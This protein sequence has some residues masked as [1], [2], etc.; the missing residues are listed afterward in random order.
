MWETIKPV[1]KNLKV[2]SVGVDAIH[3]RDGELRARMVGEPIPRH[4]SHVNM[5]LNLSNNYHDLKLD[6]TGTNSRLPLN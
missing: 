6:L 2:P 5:I 1:V 4:I 3:I